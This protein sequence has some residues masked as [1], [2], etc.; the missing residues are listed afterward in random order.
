MGKLGRCSEG[1]K[2]KRKVEEL[3]V[4]GQLVLRR[5]RAINGI[6]VKCWTSREWSLTQ[7]PELPS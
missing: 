7:L 3:K 5:A 2:E 6:K 4:T 1:L